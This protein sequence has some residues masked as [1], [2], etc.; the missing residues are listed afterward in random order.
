MPVNLLFILPTA[1]LP[2]KNRMDVLIS[3]PMRSLTFLFLRKIGVWSPF[4]SWTQ[5]FS[6]LV[7]Q[8]GQGAQG[9]RGKGLVRVRPEILASLT[10]HIVADWMQ[11]KGILELAEGKL[12]FV[13][14]EGKQKVKRKR[15]RKRQERWACRQRAEWKLKHKSWKRGL[16]DVTY[17]FIHCLCLYLL[18]KLFVL[19]TCGAGE[20]TTKQQFD[21]YLFPCTWEAQKA[22]L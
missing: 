11:I 17:C 4:S 12:Y 1:L 9:Q 20:T 14:E 10:T 3:I 7:W 18:T 21:L 22:K 6:A 16:R 13:N 19:N 8:F 2:L 5:W 15:Q